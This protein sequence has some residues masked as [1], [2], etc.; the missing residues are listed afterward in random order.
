MFTSSSLVAQSFSSS[1]HFM[2]QETLLA[3]FEKC[4]KLLFV[5]S[6]LMRILPIEAKVALLNKY[7]AEGAAELPL[8]SEHLADDFAHQMNK[9]TWWPFLLAFYEKHFD[10][11][12][13]AWTLQTQDEWVRA[14]IEDLIAS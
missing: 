3:E 12:Q 10:Q 13:G 11:T 9:E 4:R 6:Q 5:S 8:T 1:F 7:K 14:S 2:D